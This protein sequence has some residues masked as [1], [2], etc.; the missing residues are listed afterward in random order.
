MNRLAH[1]RLLEALAVLSSL[2]V[3]AC[4]GP[5]TGDSSG[6]RSATT[7]GAE[8][9][10]GEPDDGMQIE[11]TL[12][13]ISQR[14]IEDGIQRNLPRISRCFSDRYDQ[15]EVLG[16]HMEMAFRIKTDGHVRWVY[17]RH[18]TVG[19]RDTERCILNVLSRIQFER[20]RSGEAEFATPLDLDPPE[21]VRP[22]VEWA[23]SRVEPLVMEQ[24]AAL[25]ESRGASG[26]AAQVTAY[27]APGG[28]AI[29]A[30]AA[31]DAPDI[32][33]PLDCLA[34]GVRAWTWPDPGSYPAKVTFDLLP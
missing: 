10:E 11:G 33:E 27:I 4:G 17:L 13:T 8:T 15:V 21:D 7:S 16:G 20:P 5:D 29:T 12:G 9:T 14:A 3:G 30:G 25:L 23:T 18:S 24:G 32:V 6:G 1:A 28:A 31:I 22:P 34:A 26:Q 19:D 2:A